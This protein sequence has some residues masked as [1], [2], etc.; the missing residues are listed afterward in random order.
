[1]RQASDLAL[2]SV[3]TVRPDGTDD[4]RLRRAFER[5]VT[6]SRGRPASATSDRLVAVFDGPGRAVRCA[7]A[8]V[9]SA[10]RGSQP[11]AAAG[12]H[13]GECDLVRNAGPIFDLSAAMARA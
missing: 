2:A 13:V 1:T 11:A 8:L 9:R 5:E 6:S 3:L 7:V 4:L 10:V 12:V